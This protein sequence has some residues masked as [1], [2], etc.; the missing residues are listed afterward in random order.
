MFFAREP[1]T[2]F[3]RVPGI[4]M[5]VGVVIGAVALL[6]NWPDEAENS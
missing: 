6:A 2:F 5:A 3:Q 4:G 1:L